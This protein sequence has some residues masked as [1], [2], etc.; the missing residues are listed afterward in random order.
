M[1]LRRGSRRFERVGL[2]HGERQLIV[3]PSGAKCRS[4][5][6]S[7]TSRERRGPPARRI[8]L[9]DDHGA[10]A[11]IEIMPI[12]DARHDAHLAPACT[13]RTTSRGRAAPARARASGWSAIWSGSRRRSRRPSRGPHRSRHRARARI[14]STLSP[15]N[16]RVDR[17]APRRHRPL[18]RRLR[19]GRERRV[20][21][22]IAAQ[23]I[24]QV[25]EPLRAHMVGRDAGRDRVGGLEPIAG[26]RAP[27][28]DLA[29]HARQH[30]GARRHRG[31]SRSRPPAWRTGSGRRRRDA[32]RAP[33]CRRRR[34]SRCRRSAPRRASDSA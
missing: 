18:G 30:P 8:V 14:S 25:G 7:L 22:D 23:R 28:A 31:R 9:V 33:R 19:E 5:S 27:G 3:S 32:S 26:E 21:R 11:F 1:R 20:D 34:P 10:H 13:A 4:T 16:S 2:A 29:R 12:H 24:G 15:A 6:A 17:V